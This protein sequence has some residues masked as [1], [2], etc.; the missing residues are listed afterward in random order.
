[1]G[2]SL[3]RRSPAKTK[4]VH[5]YDTMESAMRERDAQARERFGVDIVVQKVGSGFI[6]RE[7]QL[8]ETKEANKASLPKTAIPA[9]KTRQE[10]LEFMDAMRAVQGYAE[11]EAATVIIPRS[12][13]PKSIYAE[14]PVR[15][16]ARPKLGSKRKEHEDS[17]YARSGRYAPAEI[18]RGWRKLPRTS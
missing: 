15:S 2:K 14:V 1:M 18:A 4:R 13:E 10:T 7:L 9:F 12:K 8:A 3:K 5:V 6:V 17:S 11:A 16:I